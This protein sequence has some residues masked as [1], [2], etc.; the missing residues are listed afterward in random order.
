MGLRECRR[1]ITELEIHA[2]EKISLAGVGCDEEITD[3]GAVGQKSA[4][5]A[6]GKWCVETDFPPIGNSIGQLG[7]AVER[8]VCHQ[9]AGKI[10][11]FAAVNCV[12]EMLFEG[13]LPDRG[14]L[15]VIDLDLIVGEG[16]A[17][18]RDQHDGGRGRFH[19]RVHGDVSGLNNPE[20][21]VPMLP[22]SCGGSARVSASPV[23]TLRIR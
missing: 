7:R 4:A 15:G 18:T 22:T 13:P 14:N 23:P 11:L 9:A 2:I 12:I 6:Y 3:L 19:T 20:S 5:A 21:A 1:L 17:G 10:R 8:M 16:G